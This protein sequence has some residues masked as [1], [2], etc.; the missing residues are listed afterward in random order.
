MTGSSGSVLAA[1]RAEVARAA[2]TAPG[3]PALTVASGLLRSVARA[4]GWTPPVHLRARDPEAVTALLDLDVPADLAEAHGPELLGV[5]YEAALAPDARD[6]GAHYTP[7]DVAARLV[8]LVAGPDV[9]VGPRPLVW[10]PACGG[11]AFLLAAADALLVRGVEPDVVV[12]DLLWGTDVDP[13]AIAIAEAALAWWAYRHGIDAAWPDEHLVAADP[14]VD[15]VPARPKWDRAERAAGHPLGVAA[16]GGFDLVLGNPPFQGQ[17]AGPSVRS[18]SA[19][20]A[21]R[22]RWG[23]DVVRPY[24]DTASLFLVAAARA[25]A[26]GGRLVLVLPTSVL[27]ARDAAPARAAASAVGD[28]NGLW[29][30]AE[31]VFDAAVQVCAVVVERPSAPSIAAVE[32]SVDPTARPGGDEVRRWRGRAFDVL[33]S[34]R[35]GSVARAAVAGADGWAALALAALGV[36][37]PSA[38]FEGR[39]GSIATARASFRDEYYGLVDHVA[40]AGDG[41]DELDEVPAGLSPLVTSGLVDPGRC[42]WGER[43]ASFART[44]YQRPV[45]DLSSLAA[46]GGRAAAW[47]AALLVPKVVV[48]TQTRVGEAAVDEVGTWVA[49]TPTIALVAEPDRLWEVAAVVCSPL[50]TVAALAATAGS[51]RAGDAIRHTV[52]SVAGLPLPVDHDAWR[53][54]AGALRRHDREAFISAMATAYAVEDTDALHDWWIA[55]AP[56][57][58]T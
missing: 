23:S 9:P 49:S 2:R 24:T 27:A 48:A 55:R 53:D 22:E 11:G 44:R 1:L 19:V 36:P 39:L 26:P 25:L 32:A 54:G 57:P 45:I 7:A 28:L 29:V 34:A 16:A 12:G 4:G 30:A 20:A 10:D 40:E 15:V 51:A 17:L 50:G 42:A 56:W 35:P 47:V 37:D 14:L 3:A 21:L 43:P 18:A 5:L 38:R 31:P 41:C 8:G 6:A 33:P 46:D 58:G 52:A 13:G